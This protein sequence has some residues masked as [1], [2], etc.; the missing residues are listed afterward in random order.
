MFGTGL[1]FCV[2][3]LTVSSLYAVPVLPVGCS[4]ISIHAILDHSIVE[5]IV[6][7]RTA[8]VTYSINTNSASETDV[9]MFGA[10]PVSPAQATLPVQAN[11]SSSA[12]PIVGCGN[13]GRLS[14]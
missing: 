5:T 3:H 10:K 13:D 4:S 11:C 1:V 14:Q 8:M 9:E 6:N 2:A 12:A 7:N